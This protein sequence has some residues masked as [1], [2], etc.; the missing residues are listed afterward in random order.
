MNVFDK[1]KTTALMYAAMAG[2][3][4]VAKALLELSADKALEDVDGFTAARLAEKE[5]HS[6]LVALLS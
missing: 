6:A 4:D 1:F 3:A 5:G 2:H